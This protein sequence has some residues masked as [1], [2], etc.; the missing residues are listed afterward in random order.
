MR[1]VSVLAFL[2]LAI[3]GIGAPVAAQGD[4]AMPDFSRFAQSD[5]DS[6]IHVDH[7]GWTIILQDIVLNVPPMDRIPERSRPITTGSR[8]STGNLSRYR[9]EGNRVLYH[10]MPDD[11]RAGIT[12]LREDLEALPERIGGL[13]GLSRD[14]QLAYWFNLHNVAVVEQVLAA[15]P[16]RNISRLRAPGTDQS[17]FEGRFLSVE[18]QALSLNDIRLRIVFE[19]WDDPRVIYGFFNGSVG[20]PELRRAA[21]EGDQVW[22]QLD[23]SADEFV[24]ALRG[25][26]VHPRKLRVSHVYEDA[27]R[28][29]SNFDRDLRIHLLVYANP[30]TR[31][32]LTGDRPLET[33]VADWQIADMINGSYRCRGAGG[34]SPL[35]SFSGSSA[36]NGVA[37]S[38]GVLPTNGRILLEAVQER[39]IELL[40]EGRYGEVFT[41]DLPSQDPDNVALDETM[42][43]EAADNAGPAGDGTD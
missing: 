42:G 11:Y 8:L 30:E 7:S 26:E 18:G 41:N 37:T 29:F 38:C 32:Q 1:I 2:V 14:E 9:H 23:A 10:M 36:V 16:V 15:Y 35:L 4:G 13:A 20:S 19:Q 31:G 43:E 22:A 6:A 27:R 5:P 34:A 21:F 3:G 39:R 25:V 24:N 33:N 17:L 40:G 12:T 28:L